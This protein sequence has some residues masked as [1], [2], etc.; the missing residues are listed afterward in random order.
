M[1]A[2]E[3]IRTA[4]RDYRVARMPLTLKFGTEE[5]PT[6]HYGLFLPDRG[7]ECLPT[8]VS[9]RYEPHTL[10]DVVA[11]AEAGMAA[12]DGEAT[13]RAHWRNGHV[14]EVSPLDSHRLAVF[15]T[16]SVI[17]RLF[18]RAQYDGRACRGTLGWYRDVCRNLAMLRSVG[19]SVDQRLVHTHDLPG[20]I[21]EL[22]DRFREIASGW[23]RITNTIQDLES[24]QVN[25]T[26]FLAKIYPTG[27]SKQ[28]E[29]RCSKR[30]ETIIARVIRER[31]RTG[32]PAMSEQT[33]ACISD[34]E[35]SGWEAYNAV[36]GYVQHCTPRHFSNSEN[37]QLDRAITAWDDP[38]VV[39]AERLA[40]AG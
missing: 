38:H 7:W 25:L 4:F 2:S 23:G 29:T 22:V 10:D 27:E 20:R 33:S 30:A 14:V 32:R 17:P 5:V 21:D 40:L 36:Q 15:G 13:I 18:I 9:A 19:G 37:V 31:F 16:D 8:T 12:F 28:S 3:T 34:W 26:K 6:P 24:R 35:V 11:L 1:N 39:A